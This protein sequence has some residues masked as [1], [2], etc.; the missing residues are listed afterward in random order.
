[1][2]GVRRASVS[3][4][5]QGGASECGPDLLSARRNHDGGPCR[6]GSGDVRGLLCDPAGVGSAC[7]PSRQ[8]NSHAGRTPWLLPQC[9]ASGISAT[10]PKATGGAHCPS[11]CSRQ[12]GRV[13][14]KL[15]SNEQSRHRPIHLRHDNTDCRKSAVQADHPNCR[16]IRQ[17]RFKHHHTVLSRRN[18]TRMGTVCRL[19][20]PTANPKAVAL[21][22]NRRN[23]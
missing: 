7:Y 1:M 18:V 16:V 9:A 10:S 2:L 5:R 14:L 3:R 8:A 11:A 13:T 21:F 23:A 6:T 15:V 12:S 22:T 17:V 4:P 19:A 20:A